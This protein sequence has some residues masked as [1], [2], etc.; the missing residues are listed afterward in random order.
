MAA[1]PTSVAV[2]VVNSGTSPATLGSVTAQPGTVA[3]GQLQLLA[4]AAPLH[5]AVGPWAASV[6]PGGAAAAGPFRVVVAADAAAPPGALLV[7][8]LPCGPAAF[9]PAAWTAT[10]FP[11]PGVPFQVGGTNG[12]WFTFAEAANG[13]AQLMVLGAGPEPLPVA[14]SAVGEASVGGPSVAPDTAWA[15]LALMDGEGAAAYQL[16]CYAAGRAWVVP[17]TAAALPWQLQ[18]MGSPA[19]AVQLSFARPGAC[20][21]PATPWNPCASVVARS[22]PPGASPCLL[23]ST[24]AGAAYCGACQG[25]TQPLTAAAAAA[26]PTAGTALPTLLLTN[27]WPAPAPVTVAV[28]GAPAASVA[29]LQTAAFPGLMLTG[30]SVVVAGWGGALAAFQLP[31]TA[32]AAGPSGS[33]LAAALRDGSAS[34]WWLRGKASQPLANVLATWDAAASTLHAVVLPVQPLEVLAGCVAAATAKDATGLRGMLPPWRPFAAAGKT[35]LLQR[36]AATGWLAPVNPALLPQGCSAAALVP[37]SA[38]TGVLVAWGSGV[39]CLGLDATWVTVPGAASPLDLLNPALAWPA[40]GPYAP[41][42]ALRASA[43]TVPALPLA[44]TLPAALWATQDDVVDAAAAP[45]GR[46]PSVGIMLAGI[47]LAAAAVLW[48]VYLLLSWRQ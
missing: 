44:L 7:R 42:A 15:P 31:A 38:D 22:C 20:G 12:A 48:G 18:P 45:G 1:T 46:G 29:F 34:E 13:T 9:A 23:A 35:W 10:G 40:A 30:S 11:P 8:V 24:R 39:Q 43:S 14:V 16:V 26:G 33:T 2:T 47:M 17:G 36:D 27:C 28:D 25:F 6:A 3:A 41:P 32:V 19:A 4:G 37:T 21:A 5:V